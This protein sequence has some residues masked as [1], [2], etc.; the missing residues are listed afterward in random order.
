M[1]TLILISM[2]TLG[3]AAD[4]LP[5]AGMKVMEE[6]TKN[7]KAARK[8]YNIA[9]VKALDKALAD[10]TKAT[11]AVT[12]KGDL[13]GANA[14][15]KKIKELQEEKEMLS[16]DP[17]ALI[18]ISAKFGAGEQWKDCT[19]FFEKV[20]K[21]KNTLEYDT[22]DFFLVVGD[23]FHGAK[24]KIVIEVIND[25]KKQTYTFNEG[26]KIKIP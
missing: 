11:K 8:V 13:D 4:V 2:F 16:F 22:A 21:D 20:M 23:P 17:D 24:K 12:S 7:E 14:I 6:Y 9:K 19:K 26:D 15:T 5:D 25:C 3:F 10:L 18:L 1:K